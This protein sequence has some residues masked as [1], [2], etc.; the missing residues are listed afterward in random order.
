MLRNA[1]MVGYGE[2]E[3]VRMGKKVYR[4]FGYIKTQHYV[5]NY[6]KHIGPHRQ[7]ALLRHEYADGVPQ[8]GSTLPYADMLGV[9]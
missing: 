5:R 9:L 2:I 7:V 6:A 3:H 8:A 4:N 1:D